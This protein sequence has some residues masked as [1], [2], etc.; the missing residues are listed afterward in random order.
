MKLF[1]FVNEGF[2]VLCFLPPFIN[3]L[4][5]KSPLRRSFHGSDIVSLSSLSKNRGL[6]F[7]MVCGLLKACFPRKP[8]MIGSTAFC[9]PCQNVALVNFT[10]EEQRIG[11]IFEKRFFSGG[12]ALINT[13]PE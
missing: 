11:F 6:C 9:P 4:V 5:S 10:K 1:T 3:M 8:F 12:V 2:P 7:Y 13:N